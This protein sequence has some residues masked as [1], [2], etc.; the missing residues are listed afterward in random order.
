VPAQGDDGDGHGGGDRA[1]GRY[2]RHAGRSGPLPLGRDEEEDGEQRGLGRDGRGMPAGEGELA[3]VR[4]VEEMLEQGV[5]QYRGDRDGG[6][7]QHHAVEPPG[8]QAADRGGGADR[9]GRN[10]RRWQREPEQEAVV[11]AEERDDRRVDGVIEPVG[12]RLSP[13]QQ[14]ERDDDDHARG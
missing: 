11:A 1:V 4:S 3:Q 6:H 13:Q 2:E 9:G 8:D 10:E 14:A 5:I 7:R 12:A